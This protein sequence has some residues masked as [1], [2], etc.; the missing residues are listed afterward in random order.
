MQPTVSRTQSVLRWLWRWLPPILWMAGIFYL[1]SQPSLPHAPDPWLDVLI[2]KLGHANEY[3]VL[4]LL[5]VRAWSTLRS[6][7]ARLDISWIATAIYALSDELHQSFVPGRHCKW[8]DVVIDV[9][10]ALLVWLLLRHGLWHR[11]F[12]ARDNDLTK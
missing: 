9:S 8:Y 7:R 5:F 1:S 12:G 10:G 11:L 4:F 2:K 6:A 3:A